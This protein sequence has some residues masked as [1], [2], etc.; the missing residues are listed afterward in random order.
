MSMEF[1]VKAAGF[2]N[3]EEFHSLVANVDL[4][5]TEKLVAFQEWQIKDGSK[6]GLLKLKMM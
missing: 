2:N 4:S 5:S 3:E 1:F 6:E